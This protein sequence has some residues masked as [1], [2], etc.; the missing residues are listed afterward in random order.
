MTELVLLIAMSNLATAPVIFWIG[1]NTAAVQQGAA[2]ASTWMH[3]F[4]Q[5]DSTDKG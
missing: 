1:V 5:S 4:A 2:I 3:A